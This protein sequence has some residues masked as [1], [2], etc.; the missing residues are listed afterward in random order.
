M[1]FVLCAGCSH[2]EPDLYALSLGCVWGTGLNY[3]VDHKSG[4]FAV[5]FT[6][7]SGLGRSSER[8]DES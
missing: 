1:D 2:G 7:D 5:F 8:G 6:S 3:W 4:E